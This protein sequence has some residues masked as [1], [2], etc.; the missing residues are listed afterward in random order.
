M[1]ISIHEVHI[2]SFLLHFIKSHFRGVFYGPPGI[3]LK[4]TLGQFW[5][6]YSHFPQTR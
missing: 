2:I 3:I 4:F 6:Q 1:L 5:G